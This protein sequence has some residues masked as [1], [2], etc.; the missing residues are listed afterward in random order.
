MPRR[1]HASSISG[2]TT[3]SYMQTAAPTAGCPSPEIPPLGETV[4]CARADVAMPTHD[5]SSTAPS[6]DRRA[7][8]HAAA[9]TG[10]AAVA[11]IANGEVTK[12]VHMTCLHYSSHA[13]DHIPQLDCVS[14]SL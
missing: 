8:A 12:D 4:I 2:R 13:P 10:F 6:T 11:T 1:D 5:R 9:F 14:E 7:H 3:P